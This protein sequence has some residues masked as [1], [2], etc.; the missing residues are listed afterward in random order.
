MMMTISSPKQ[1]VAGTVASTVP[2]CLFR[3]VSERYL[4][5]GYDRL[6]GNLTLSYNHFSTS[7][8]QT[9][10][11]TYLLHILKVRSQISTRR[12]AILTEVFVG[13]L[14]PSRRIPGQ[15]LKIRPLPLPSK[16]SYFIIHLEPFH[17][18]LHSL[19]N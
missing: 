11:P 14:S 3:Q 17:S 13:F 7:F 15:Y 10:W 6:L 19:R 12:L 9:S 18:T 2:P 4:Q 8:D 16:P 1:C 5:L